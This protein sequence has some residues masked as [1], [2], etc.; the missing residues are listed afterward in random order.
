[1]SDIRNDDEILTDESASL[2]DLLKERGLDDEKSLKI[3]ANVGVTCA[4]DLRKT[5]VDELMKVS[6]R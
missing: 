6:F 1:M 5:T 4:E 3:L 2:K